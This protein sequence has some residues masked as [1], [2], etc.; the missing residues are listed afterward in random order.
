M[1][2]GALSATNN[3]MQRSNNKSLKNPYTRTGVAGHNTP[4]GRKRSRL[5]KILPRVLLAVVIIAAII[6]AVT[7]VVSFFGQ[8][9]KPVRINATPTDN[10]QPFGDTVLFYDGAT[11]HCVNTNGTTKWQY[12]LGIDGD[13]YCTDTLII[14]WSGNQI[15]VLNRDGKPTYTNR[16][17]LPIRFAR[18]GE[19]YAAICVGEERSSK[20]I[21]M[22]H[23][24]VVLEEIQSD[25]D[26]LYVL[27]MGFFNKGQLMWVLGLDVSSNAPISRI[28]A[29]EP[30]KR[31]GG[32]AESP[33]ELI[34][35]VYPQGNNLMVVD[36]S[37]I[38]T[39]DYRLTEQ[40]DLSSI[41][42]YGWQVR[43]V[44]LNGRNTHVLLQQMPQSGSQSTFSELRVV[45]NYDM[46]SYRL[47]TPCFAG[48]LTEKGV[49]GI[50]ANVIYY[51]PYGTN[52][53]K[54]HPLNY[55]LSGY[56]CTLKGGYGVMVSGNDVFI[57]QL[58]T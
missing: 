32:I 25:F 3:E 12:S 55:Q 9:T 39:Y 57:M 20:I 50:G 58:P 37:R 16:L 43:Q 4:G 5:P 53:F 26:G 10:I 40:T 36:T 30:G 41:L 48:A 34:Y 13:Y 24:G 42:V 15:H 28:R 7:L 56:L 14:A 21:A 46:Q 33:D 18:I 8:T 45:T 35:R 29:Y 23:N 38:R 44:L 54:A 1:I 49:Y 11:L 22:T 52:T 51:A 27:D 6:G 19:T 31:S 47:L 17:D 2:C